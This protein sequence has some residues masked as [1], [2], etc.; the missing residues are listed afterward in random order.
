MDGKRLLTDVV[1]IRPLFIAI[2]V[3]Y[4]AFIIYMGGWKEPVRFVP[5]KA[6]DWLANFLYSVRMQGFVFM[7]GYVYAYQVLTLGRNESLKQIVTKKFKRLIY[8]K[9]ILQRDLFF[10]VL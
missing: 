1:V 5:V 8:A 9:H 10:H 7:A 2:V 6:Y 3:V 4:H